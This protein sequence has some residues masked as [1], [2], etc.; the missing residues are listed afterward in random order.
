MKLIEY[1]LKSNFRPVYWFYNRIN[2]LVKLIN[3]I[4]DNYSKP[5]SSLARFHFVYPLF[6]TLHFAHLNF[7]LL[8][9]RYAPLLKPGVK[10]YFIFTVMSLSFKNK[11]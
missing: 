7:N 4:R 6:K 1:Y 8:P 2:K 11:K 10:M 9:I 5:T 3:Y